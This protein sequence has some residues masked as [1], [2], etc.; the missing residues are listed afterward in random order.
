MRC[1]ILQRISCDFHVT[2]WSIRQTYFHFPYSFPICRQSAWLLSSPS[3]LRTY[4]HHPFYRPV[5]SLSVPTPLAQSVYSLTFYLLL[6]LFLL[7]SFVIPIVDRSHFQG[8]PITK[9][10]TQHGTQ[11]SYTYKPLV[12]TFKQSSD[13]ENLNS[14]SYNSNGVQTL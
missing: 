1:I 6:L 2:L 5:C 13:N 10:K 12:R 11:L 14:R 4:F 7:K 3:F 8:F 9:H